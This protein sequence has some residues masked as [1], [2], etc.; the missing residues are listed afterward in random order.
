MSVS[1]IPKT[2]LE[3]P[4]FLTRRAATTSPSSSKKLPE[5]RQK[6]CKGYFRSFGFGACA[7]FS[8]NIDLRVSRLQISSYRQPNETCASEMGSEIIQIGIGKVPTKFA[9]HKDLVCRTGEAM[10]ALINKPLAPGK[11]VVLAAE[12]PAIFKLFVELMYSRNVP[13]VTETMVPVAQAARINQLCQLYAFLEKY[14][15]KFDIRNKVMDR[16]QDGFALTNL[17]P[18]PGIVKAIYQHTSLT[19]P[20]RNFCAESMLYHLHSPNYVANGVIP[21]LMQEKEFA[22]DFLEAI[23]KSKEEAEQPNLDPRIRHC[24][25]D[26]GCLECAGNF[27]RLEGKEGRYP[28]HFHK[29]R[30]LINGKEVYDPSCH[31]W[32]A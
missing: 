18:E 7:G 5:R 17:L 10:A 29:H 20:L 27:S 30:G 9:I 24:G 8:R 23:R 16:I 22:N 1:V 28:C 12:D 14:Q 11:I 32:K 2:F 4:P 31:L 13:A 6:Q 19:S 15:V 26:M 3:L 25:K 21:N